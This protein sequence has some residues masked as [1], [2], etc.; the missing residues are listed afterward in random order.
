MYTYPHTIENGVGERLV[1]LRKVRGQRGDRLEGE[2]VVSPAPVRRCT[3][4][5][6][7]KKD[8]L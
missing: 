8:S 7:R 4:I 3:C 2:N 1:F 6:F 5:F